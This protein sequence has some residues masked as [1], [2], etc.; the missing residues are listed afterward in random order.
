MFN[1]IQSI[2]RQRQVIWELAVHE[3]RSRYLGSIFG[4]L[5]AFFLPLVNLFIMWFAF[6]HG[7]KS[8][9]SDGLP[10]LL[11][12]VTG[13]FPWT[14]FSEA[15]STSATSIVEKTFLVKK[16]TFSVELLPLIKVVSLT[17]VFLFLNIIMFL[18]FF[19]YQNYPSLYWLQLPYFWICLYC[20]I[21]SI[22]WITSSLVVLY[23]DVAQMITVTLQLLFWATPIFWSPEA[24]PGKY[25][26]VI[27][28]N[29]LNY[30]ITGYRDSLINKVWFWET[31][32]S[33]L[34]FWATIAILF[35]LGQTMFKR[36]RPHFADVL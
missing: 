5:W 36:L 32:K 30:V 15:I 10:F 1:F 17:F 21:F 18:L 7:L 28:L 12:L 19:A 34:V 22:C 2:S 3:F 13:L 29:P 9:P 8:H 11:W 27:K 31:P 4:V 16:V 33:I 6:E 25:Q 23:R 24:L 35:F 14:F 20:F 26:F